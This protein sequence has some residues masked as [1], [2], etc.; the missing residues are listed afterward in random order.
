MAHL[1]TRPDQ[2]GTI[3]Q[4][5]EATGVGAP[6][7]RKVLDKLRAAGVISTQRGSGGGVM[8]D[9]DPNSLTLL[10]VVNAVDPVTRIERCPL[11]L[12]DHVRLCALHSELDAALIQ[13]QNVLASRTIGELL[14]AE[15]SRKPVCLFPRNY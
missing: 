9:V 14:A 15:Q 7:L 11:G 4:M 1:A 6:Y 3:S 2:T 12:P 8:L 10:D 5:S 13:L